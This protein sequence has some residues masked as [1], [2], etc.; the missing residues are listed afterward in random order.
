MTRGDARAAVQAVR[1]LLRVAP[2]RLGQVQ[3]SARLALEHGHPQLAARLL[4]QLPDTERDPALTVRAFLAAGLLDKVEGVLATAA[5]EAFGGRVDKAELWLEAGH[6][7]RAAELGR[8][9][10]IAEP[11]PRAWLVTGRA[12][13]AR[14]RWSQAAS[15]LARVPR[16]VRAYPR[17]R[18][19]LA[20]A[21]RAQALDT[22][23]AEVLAR[24][25][26]HTEEVALR[27]ALAETRFGLGDLSA[28]LGALGDGGDASPRL[29]AARAS[30]L[31]RAGRLEAANRIYRR[32]APH[33]ESLP[34]SARARCKA[35]R[36]L[37]KGKLQGAIGTLRKRAE[38]APEDLAS[39]VRLVELLVRAG[40]RTQ[41]RSR[42]DSLGPQLVRPAF[43]KRLQR[44]LDEGEAPRPSARDGT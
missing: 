15:Q 22:L 7:V 36:Q 40:D 11:S 18:L 24:A 14:G 38:Q 34:E 33:S 8:A 29:S 39:R 1:D 9:A 13:L 20:K 10:A 41:A 19:A 31:E 26:R 32:L 3:R 4:E 23:A 43:R 16:G 44:A 27:T 17:A 25:L 12:E 30:L 21:L 5:P 37:A 35:E 6:P 42:G 2:A 28:A